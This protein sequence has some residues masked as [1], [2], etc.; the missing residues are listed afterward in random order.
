[1]HDGHMQL[2][3]VLNEDSTA[4]ATAPETHTHVEVVNNE[5]AMMADPAVQ[6]AIL[7]AGADVV[8]VHV[9]V[10]ESDEFLGTA[11]AGV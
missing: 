7:D 2:V 11:T 10:P 3:E 9:A 8:G 6:P 5:A 1:V 4:S